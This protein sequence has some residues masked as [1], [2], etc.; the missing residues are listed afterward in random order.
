[1][2]RTRPRHTAPHKVTSLGGG[3]GNKL[4][5]SHP[6]EKDSP[7]AW[8]VADLCVEGGGRVLCW[9]PYSMEGSRIDQ[10]GFWKGTSG[11]LKVKSSCCE[12]A[13]VMGAECVRMVLV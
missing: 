9:N 5:F 10:R 7:T 3:G 1:M 13:S 8:S 12:G 11:A 4:P 6:V 2:K